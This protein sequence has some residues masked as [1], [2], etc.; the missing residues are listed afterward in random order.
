M[1][2]EPS[3]SG[4]F[5]IPEND[6]DREVFLQWHRKSIGLIKIEGLNAPGINRIELLTFRVLREVAADMK[7]E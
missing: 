6:L 2:V 7:V 1:K 5:L 3:L 4:F